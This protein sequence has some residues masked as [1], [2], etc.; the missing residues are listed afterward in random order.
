MW[1]GGAGRLGGPVGRWPVDGEVVV[2]GG[3]VVSGNWVVPTAPP[4]AVVGWWMV[5]GPSHPATEGP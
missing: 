4:V 1:S 2:G 5:T 3:A